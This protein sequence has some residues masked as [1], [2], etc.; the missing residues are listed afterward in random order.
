M[1]AAFWAAPSCACQEPSLSLFG[2][3]LSRA[4]TG[5]TFTG[6]KAGLVVSG[7]AAAGAFSGR[8]FDLSLAEEASAAILVSSALNAIAGGEIRGA[9]TIAGAGGA[10]ELGASATTCAGLGGTIGLEGFGGGSTQRMQILQARGLADWTQPVWTLPQAGNSSAPASRRPRAHICIPCA[11]NSAPAGLYHQRSKPVQ[12]ERRERVR[13]TIT[14]QSKVP[15]GTVMVSR[16]STVQELACTISLPLDEIFALE[17]QRRGALSRHG[18]H[19]RERCDRS[20]C[21]SRWRWRQSLRMK[22][23]RENHWPGA[24]RRS[25]TVALRRD[26]R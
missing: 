15:A 1:A 22:P 21:A 25:N 23:S 17:G 12:S 19:R 18:P 13:H 4:L 11:H 16:P 2:I 14:Q 9:A 8:D 24:S 26:G 6:S 10:I 20:S 3:G 7:S 5:V